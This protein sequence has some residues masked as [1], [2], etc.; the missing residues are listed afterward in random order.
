MRRVSHVLALEKHVNLTER[1]TQRV[2]ALPALTHQVVDLLGAG[3]RRRQLH[4][5]RRHRGADAA[6][7]AAAAGDV[8]EPA[9]FDHLLVVETGERLN[10]SQTEHLPQRYGERPHVAFRRESALDRTDVKT[11]INKFENK[12]FRK[13]EI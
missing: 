10:A 1:R 11:L 9:V 2:V 8:V 3:G 5:G 13:N 7:A 4:G 6:A 12:T